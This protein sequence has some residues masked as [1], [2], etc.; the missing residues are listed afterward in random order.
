MRNNNNSV[1]RGKKQNRGQSN[2]NKY[3]KVGDTIVLAD[4][5]ISFRSKDTNDDVSKTF[6]YNIINNQNLV[7]NIDLTS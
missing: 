3:L 7:N 4:Q 1:N 2:N 5:Q 6:N